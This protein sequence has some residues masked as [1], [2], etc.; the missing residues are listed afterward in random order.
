MEELG[1]K[2]GVLVRTT[3]E[4]LATEKQKQFA[5]KLGL[6]IGENTTLNEASK[7]IDEAL[8]KQK[9][10]QAKSDEQIAG[11]MQKPP[12]I[13]KDTIPAK[14]ETTPQTP[15]PY[16]KTAY[17][18]PFYNSAGK[19]AS[20]EK[21]FGEKTKRLEEAEKLKIRSMAVSFSKDLVVAGKIDFNNMYEE[22]NN[23]IAF[24]NR[25]A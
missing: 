15:K 5:K 17:S 1:G 4:I 25:V 9:D 24:I 3:T 13:Q 10:K 16:V 2:G 6:E 18:K 22:A 14:T 12:E 11:T 21:M 8:K 23:I 20:I 7:M 19:Q